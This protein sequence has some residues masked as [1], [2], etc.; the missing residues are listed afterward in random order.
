M[1][2]GISMVIDDKFLERLSA[3]D[4][5]L[6]ELAKKSEDVRG[7]VIQSFKSMGDDGVGYFIQKINEA[8]AALHGMGNEGGKI[9]IDA[10]GIE[11]VG[12]SATKS[13]DEVNKLIDIVSK[14][15]EAN[16]KIS[17]QQGLSTF[18]QPK[19]DKPIDMSKSVTEY[20]AL[21]KNI[22]SYQQ[23]I[24]KILPSIKEYELI[25]NRISSGKGGVITKQQQE[26][27]RLNIQIVESLKQKI[28]ADQQRQQIIIQEN[29]SIQTQIR[30]KQE[31]QNMTQKDR[32]SAEI[33]AKMSAYYREQAIEAERLARAKN[34]SYSG[35]MAYSSNAKTYIEEKQAIEYL[36]T[37]RNNL[38]KADTDFAN[39]RNALNEAINKHTES[40][41]RS[42]MTD[43]QIAEESAKASEKRRQAALKEAEAYE[44]RKK[45]VM[46]KWYSSSADRAL[47]FSASTKSINE[48]VQAIKYLQIARAN[49]SKGNMTDEQ[50]RQKVNRLTEEIKR[51]QT[52]VDKLVGKN[53]EL[54]NSHRNLMDIS[55]Q[56]MR[57]MALVFSVSQIHGYINKLATVRGEFELQQKS[58][59]VLLQNKDEANKLWQQTVELAVK[60]PFRVSEL[61][62]YTRQLAAY[63]IE[64]SNLHETTRKL[65]DVSAGLG[66]DMNRLILA[67]GQVRAAEY[68]RGTELRQFTEA[69]I[70]MLDELA[71]RFSALEGHMITAGDVFERISKRMV[72][73]KDV[74]AVFDTMT[75]AG[76]NFYRMQ[77]QQSETLKGQISNLHDA[78]D[79]MLNDIGKANDGTL[80]G[81]VQLARSVVDNWREVEFILT[82]IIYTMVPA[83]LAMMSFALGTKNAAEATLWWNNAM[84]VKIGTTMADIRSLTWQ[85]AKILGVTRAQYMAGKAT[86]YFQGAL[87]GVGIALKTIAPFLAIGL[88]LEL[89]RRM[90]EASRAAEELRKNLNKL[91]NEDYGNVKTLSENY[92]S[93]VTQLRN[94]NEGSKE[95]R[96]IIAK[97]NGQYGEYLDM[98]V[99]EK[100]NVN[101]LAAA[102]E[103][104]LK[105]MKEKAALSTMEKGLNTIAESYGSKLDKAEEKFRNLF[106]GASIKNLGDNFGYI[107]PTE[108]DIDN[109]M[110]L[111]QT[112]IRELDAEQ[113]D[114]LQE[115]QDIIQEIV[116]QYYGQD[117]YLGRDYSKSI[118]LINIL[119]EKKKEEEKLEKRINSQYKEILKSREA[120][121]A[122]EKLNNE[123]KKKQI[124]INKEANLSD[125][126]V[127]QKLE[128]AKERY[129]LDK[130]ELKLKFGEI[131]ETEA[132]RAKERI[133]NWAT[134]TVKD[135]NEKLRLD[136][137]LFG[138]TEEQMATIYISQE[139]QAQG[140]AAVI[141]HTIDGWNTA[142]EIIAEQI[143]LKSAG[144]SIDEKTLKKYQDQEVLFRQ[145]A[146]ALGIELKYVTKIN[147]ETWK[148]IN[149][150]LP[151][152]YMITL[153]D[154]YKSI[155]TLLDDYTK[156]ENE[157][158]TLLKRI[159]EQK[160]KGLE[161]DN[162]QV[163]KLEEQIEQYREIRK[164][165]GEV[166]EPSISTESLNAINS[167][168]PTEYQI[169]FAES[170]K[171]VT[172]L[173]NDAN[174]AKEKAIKLNKTYQN[175]I[176][177]G[178]PVED[179]LIE[180]TKAD[181][182]WY[183][184][185]WQ[186][187]GG[188]K[189]DK[190]KGSGRSNSLYDERIKVI[191]DMNKK[192]KE[193][194][195]TLG[196]TDALQGAFSAYVD[197][198]A[199]AYNEIS[200]I[201][202]NVRQM[203]AEEFATQVLNFP[204]EDA[205]VAFLDKLSKE[206]MK[207]FEKIKV[208]LAKGK[209][210][211][212]MK[213]NAK[214]FDD[215]ELIQQI[216]DLFSGYE[217]SIE[218]DKMNIPT[219][220]AKDLF[221]IDAT[222]L[223][224]L[225]AKLQD[226][227]PLFIGTDMEEQYK[228]YL[229]KISDM[230]DKARM[231]RLKK[232]ISFL[233]TTSDEIAIA[234]TKGATDISFAKQLFSE[235]K[236]DASQY[237]DIVKNIVSNVN[238]EISKINLNK[239]KDSP[240]YIAAMGDMAGYT[241][242][243]LEKIAQKIRNIIAEN[244]SLMTPE[245][246]KVYINALEKVNE[247]TEKL[248]NPFDK[249]FI[250]EIAEIKD[251]EAQLT[252]E[253]K[254][255]NILQAEL[256]EKQGVLLELRQRLKELQSKESTPETQ[257]QINQ[258]MSDITDTQN[259]ISNVNGKLNTTAGN[260]SNIGN[261]LGNLTSG[262][263]SSL[264]IVDKIVK[265]IYQGIE[266]TRALY[267]DFKSMMDSF[268]VDTESG[269]WQDMTIAMDTLGNVNQKAMQGFV[270]FQSGN[271][272]GAVANT[273][274]AVMS[275]VSGFNAL[276]D[277]K[278]ERKIQRELKFV[279]DLQHAYEKLE[280][281]IDD[282]YAI[283]TL[284][285]STKNAKANLQAQIT[286]YYKMIAAEQDKKDTDQDRIKKWR[287]A[288]EDLREQIKELDEQAFNQATGN[289]I[290]NV[291]NAAT[292]FTDAWLEAF[293][294]T[295]NGLTGLE[296]N[297][298]EAVTNMLKQQA[299]MLITSTYVDKWKKNLEKY[300]NT[301]DLELTTT[302][303]KQWVEDVKSTLPQLN[304]ALKEYF[305]AMKGAGIDL[306]GNYEMSG[307]Q[308]SIHS[309][310]EETGQILESYLN[311][312]RFYVAE[313]NTLLQNIAASL[314]ASNVDNP[315]V[316]Q[317]KIIAS[318]TTAI[319]N[320]LQGCTKGGHRLG[321]MGLKIFMD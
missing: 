7:R 56:L 284:G 40:L 92:K 35:A 116:K 264:A 15:A 50:Y 78:I 152:E 51:Q 201:P 63:R 28:S 267:S 206:P 147:E 307:L 70:P 58:L 317:L 290:D 286:S 312:V 170:M 197:A 207:T 221:D 97:L 261:K 319:N 14:L 252:A 75:S 90:T 85:E 132:Q 269:G 257:Q 178:I 251:L 80:K 193:I 29:Q 263:S 4:T 223:D 268:G 209:Y 42:G 30:H 128:K 320:L 149:D 289:I 127:R 236:I 217:L 68:L 109:I 222:S 60:S 71:K 315:M 111:L 295:G 186:Y 288:I 72:S 12:T 196:K 88:I 69:G 55:G 112:R 126:E 114:S 299:S 291:L 25:Q 180:K 27:Y 266:A 235:G 182:E 172:E 249:T 93:L 316:E 243:E 139:E 160:K 224:E 134:D 16:S 293:K 311:S 34:T 275:L 216:E 184:K 229:N 211:Y 87:R 131:S 300:I 287:Y 48:Q 237:V 213:V 272:A 11:V 65:A 73:F 67:Y 262:M 183:T 18:N 256:V 190:K 247:Q 153:E 82:K 31:L 155:N 2:V 53:R 24:D 1:A 265:G 285:R 52:E 19:T 86:L 98:V 138:Y 44:R 135:V 171:S 36:T 8:K 21:A 258:T 297:F 39:K 228:K 169:N 77:E 165:L 10:K 204:N 120:N 199:T 151:N 200:W 177:Q 121:I 310:S 318:Q 240:E 210:V 248:K 305:N 173:Q 100:T 9:S 278:Y 232:F 20:A 212:D 146:K 57:K 203:T 119:I 142:N 22:S 96:D 241:A 105:R 202:K 101:D 129:E 294:E 143:S 62:S 245:E 189:E 91:V 226:L 303:A 102:Y 273:A 244:A 185:K 279:E 231:E 3:A 141:K 234:Q 270:D 304:N 242:K 122:L 176:A 313:Q 76:G 218:L 225:K 137:D 47:N 37:A 130:I 309:L 187:L 274:G 118:E 154:S 205:L 54:A 113:M 175:Q 103:D 220:M 150:K 158:L 230:E 125:F 23:Q 192:Y 179:E 164:M 13:A 74:A 117:F 159:Y 321:G 124:D 43:A 281:A 157:S 5:K 133:L 239:F 283:D 79:L 168:L 255:Q 104:V 32:E 277:A 84:K 89:W 214:V 166:I 246:V 194:N 250:Q 83:K 233:K 26:E 95:R 156:K 107:I 208:E 59:Q 144:L 259:E 298:K 81:G 99:D 167:L 198:F 41:K 6:E 260:I 110:S 301:D 296:D 123:Y 64:T 108:D 181:I 253:K 148:S 302:E 271:I 280:K 140:M 174:T 136:K 306:G 46:D 191:D 66:V 215:K 145:R 254:K 115:Q 163:E 38:S 162:S 238:E 292:E 195:K 314:G 308:R 33:L 227:K 219:N 49:L 17:K 276:H 188:I 61:V 282:A 106:K 161:V 45:A 94:A